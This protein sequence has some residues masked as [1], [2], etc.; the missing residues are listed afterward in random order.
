VHI[1]IS[2]RKTNV[3]GQVGCSSSLSSHFFMTCHTIVAPT[4]MGCDWGTGLSI[5]DTDSVRLR[6]TVKHCMGEDR[7]NGYISLIIIIRFQNTP[8]PTLTYVCPLLS[9]DPQ[10]SSLTRRK[11]ACGS[12]AGPYISRWRAAGLADCYW[13]VISRR[14]YAGTHSPSTRWLMLFSTFG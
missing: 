10:Q 4:L 12:F 7:K 5:R 6:C 3:L 13:R 8:R 11:T 14:P 1:C 9:D 2:S